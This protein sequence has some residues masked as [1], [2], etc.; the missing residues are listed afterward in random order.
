MEKLETPDSVL[1]P[2]V[3][4]K[5]NGKGTLFL[6]VA[7]VLAIPVLA[8]G[9][10]MMWATNFLPPCGG[11]LGLVELGV[12]GSWVVAVPTALF[13]LLAGLTVKNGSSSL[14]RTC[15]VASAVLLLPPM[16]TSVSFSRWHCS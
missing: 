12:V 4:K 11:A 8:W 16:I 2:A 13:A 7:I 15:L 10:F 3:D 1:T 9:I 14:R 5:P 6:V